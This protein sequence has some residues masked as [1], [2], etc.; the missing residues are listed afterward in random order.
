MKL[1]ENEKVRE[2]SHQSNAF[3]TS[4]KPIIYR[5]GGVILAMVV[6]CFITAKACGKSPEIKKEENKGRVIQG[7]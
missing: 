7:F 4:V 6:I 1:P 3:P 2:D 5:I